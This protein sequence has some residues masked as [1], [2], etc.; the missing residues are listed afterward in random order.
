[1]GSFF[2]DYITGDKTYMEVAEQ[3]VVSID[4][5]SLRDII[6]EAY[7]AGAENAEKHQ[8]CLRGHRRHG[9]AHRGQQRDT[10]FRL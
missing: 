4:T 7:K 3:P 1:M 9:N 5:N 2:D 10:A 8:P 6:K